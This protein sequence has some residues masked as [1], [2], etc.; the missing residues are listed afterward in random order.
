MTVATTVGLGP[1]GFIPVLHVA[2]IPMPLS[3]GVSFAGADHAGFIGWTFRAPGLRVPPPP[4]TSPC[5]CR[6]RARSAGPASSSITSTAIRLR[7]R[8]ITNA[9]R[10]PMRVT[11][12]P[13]SAFPRWRRRRPGWRCLRLPTA[14]CCGSATE[15]R[16]C[17]WREATVRASTTGN[18]ETASWSITEK[19]G[20]PSIAT[21]RRA[22]SRSGPATT[23]RPAIRSGWSACRAL[24]EFPHLHF[25]LR[26][27]GKVVDPF[28]FG[29]EASSCG[30]GTALWEP[31]TAAA[32][33]YRA[34]SVL[35]KGFAE[36]PVT[37]AAVELGRDG[38]SDTPVR[39]RW[40]P[41]CAPSG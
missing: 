5:A 14:R 36:G 19:A 27:D 40:W 33:A 18:A 17:R 26:H 11:T 28:A 16:T 15:W 20:K 37:M 24:T 21:W 23:S 25:T 32:L 7:P 3:G 9:V 38:G 13:I 34:G 10:S 4:R 6:W 22:A 39:P 30:G 41:M 35:N 12:A 29:A 31:A 1:A 8:R 2:A